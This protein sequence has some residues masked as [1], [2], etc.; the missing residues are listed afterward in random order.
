MKFNNEAL[1]W[2]IDSRYQTRKA[3][4]EAIGVT[5]RTFS[6]YMKSKNG[7]PAQFIIKAVELLEILPEEIGLYFFTPCEQ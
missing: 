3:F 6:N 5:P 7:F 2:R 4:C 1:L